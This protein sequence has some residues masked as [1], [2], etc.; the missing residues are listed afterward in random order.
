VFAGLTYFGLTP[1]RLSK[2]A[3]TAK[4]EINK[5]TPWQR[6]RLIYAIALSLA[7]IYMIAGGLIEFTL[8]WSL[9]F[10]AAFGMLWT[11]TIVDFWGLREKKGE[12]VFMKVITETI[13]VFVLIFIASYALSDMTLLE[14]VAYPAATIG[15]GCVSG[16][17]RI[18]IERK[19]EDRCSSKET[20]NSG[21]TTK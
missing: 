12:K 20:N 9:R 15:V 8:A 4:G 2:Y 19:R 5:R 18:Y 1:R 6:G 3:G 21:T 7:Y 17:V 11:I 10:T 14:K 16:I 13:L